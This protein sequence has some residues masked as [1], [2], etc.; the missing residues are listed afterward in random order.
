MGL[1]ILES[2]K[3]DMV[4]REFLDQLQFS[5][6]RLECCRSIIDMITS[7]ISTSQRVAMRR[8]KFSGLLER[9]RIASTEDL[10]TQRYM[11]SLKDQ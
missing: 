6:E 8:P 3:A 7:N 11:E 9:P 1:P 2:P 10:I 4:H 5:D